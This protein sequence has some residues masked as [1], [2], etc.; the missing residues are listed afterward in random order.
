MKKIIYSAG[1]AAVLAIVV[2]SCKKSGSETA[3]TNLSPDELA[4][5]SAAG[6]NANWAER[7][8]DG[9]YLIEGDILLTKAQLEEMRGASPTHNFIVADEEHYRTN[10]VVSTPSTGVR[11]ITVSLGA[12]FPSYYSAALDNA[13]ARY[14]N[15]GDLKIVF[16]RVASGGNIQVS[17][18]NLGI[19]PQADVF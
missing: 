14:N 17:G 18:A 10:N 7:N 4:M 2:I 15:L 16:Q 8:A 11:T 5:V 19:L 13:L 9:N 3:V 12:G 1:I 6:F